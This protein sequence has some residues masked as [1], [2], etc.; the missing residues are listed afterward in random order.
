MALGTALQL[1]PVWPDVGMPNLTSMP[2]RSGR[3]LWLAISRP[4]WTH[5]SYG[6]FPLAMQRA[7]RTVLLIAARGA[8]AGSA[9]GEPGLSAG[10]CGLA[11]LPAHMLEHILGVAAYPLSA[12]ARAPWEAAAAWLAA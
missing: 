1:L 5:A 12:W 2:P 10:T 7:A 11:R 9:P 6:R 3:F 4:A 8:A